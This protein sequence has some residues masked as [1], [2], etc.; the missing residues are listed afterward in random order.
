MRS[1]FRA[2]AR[3][4]PPY[5]VLGDWSSSL[6]HPTQLAGPRS[7]SRQVSEA[8]AG[9]WR[10]VSYPFAKLVTREYAFRT[11]STR[12]P[13]TVSTFELFVLETNLA[14]G[15]SRS[16]TSTLP[17]NIF[18]QP[19]RAPFPEHEASPAC[20][21]PGRLSWT[22]PRGLRRSS[23]HL[24]NCSPV[25]ATQRVITCMLQRSVLTFSTRS[26]ANN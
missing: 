12:L 20:R 24:H 15:P 22:V 13:P 14:T 19:S 9:I 17:Q 11:Q 2:S 21:Q 4:C 18:V 3:T 26:L 25:Q 1:I 5:L 10:W 7:R 23:L 16:L 6:R 8:R